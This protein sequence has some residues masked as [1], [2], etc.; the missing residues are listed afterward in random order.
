M[1]TVM[2][3][4]DAKRISEARVPWLALS[5]HCFSMLSVF[6]VR[7]TFLMQKES[8][9]FPQTAPV[10]LILTKDYPVMDCCLLVV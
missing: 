6:V 5:A 9:T 7:T 10:N 1:L 2:V 8:N 3:V 4:S